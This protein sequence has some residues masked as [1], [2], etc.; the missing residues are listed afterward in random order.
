MVKIFVEDVLFDDEVVCGNSILEKLGILCI[1][2]L[3]EGIVIVG[4]VFLLNDGVLVVIFVFKEYVENNNLFYLV[5]IKE[6]VEVG[7]D[8]S[9]M[10][11]VLI[12]V[13]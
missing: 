10:G 7:I 2:F 6:V 12:I 4:N 5:I 3:E 13:I 9:I 1:V 8:L 11:I